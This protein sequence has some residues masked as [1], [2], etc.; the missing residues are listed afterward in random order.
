MKTIIVWFRNDLRIND[1]PALAA[2]IDDAD[3]VIPVFLIDNAL[4]KGTNSSSNRNRF[5]IECLTDLKSSLKKIGGDLA[6]RHGKPEVELLRLAQEFKASAIYYSAGFTP[7]SIRRDK[8]VK[9]ALQKHD[10]DFRSFSG[11][12]AVSSLTKLKTKS[13]TPHKVFTPFWKQWMDVGR[14]DLAKTPKAIKLPKGLKAENLPSESELLK[15]AELSESVIKGGETEARLSLNK[16]LKGEIKNYHQNNNDM[17]NDNTSRLSPYLHFGCLSPREIETMLP[18]NKGARA[19][20]R[21]LA[22]REFYNNIIFN[23]PHPEQEFQEKY[24]KL[25][26]DNNKKLLEAWQNGQTGYPIVDAGMRQ[27]KQ[28][29]WMHNRARLIVGS[30]FTKDLWL[31]WR[32]GEN[33]F[34]TWLL[35]GDMANNNGNWQ[36]IA[37]VGVDPAPVYRRLYNPTLQQANF[38]PTGGYVRRYVKELKNVPDKYLAEPWLMPIEEQNKANCIIGKDYPKPIIDHK[39]ARQSALENYRN[40]NL[41]SAIKN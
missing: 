29:G 36:W 8:T 19:W 3:S 5:L 12:L 25:K 26:W 15:K 39:V 27:L 16:F 33:H 24:R 41:F 14:R 37:S 17:A 18:D 2:A 28:E 21:Q 30:F 22:W 7:Y 4:T 1:H 35:D 31:D 32:L 23:F 38:D 34:M 6:I 40:I 10:L 20:R 11:Y 13:G 9:S